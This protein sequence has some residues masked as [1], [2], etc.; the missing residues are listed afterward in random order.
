[1]EEYESKEL[2]SW[3]MKE[4]NIPQYWSKGL[5]GNGIKIAVLDSGINFNHPDIGT[6]VKDGFNALNPGTLPI[7]DYGHGTLMT[8]IIGSEH[9][10]FG[11][12]GIAP[13]SEIYPVKVLDRFGEGEFV[14]I[15]RGIDWCIDNNIDV[16]N[17]SF[18]VPEDHPELKH[19]I[20]K[21]LDKNI[22]IVAS[23]MN[24]YGEIS[25]YPASYNGVISVTSVDKYFRKGE[26]A[27]IGDIDFAMPGVDVITTSNDLSYQYVSGTSIA[28]PH[29]TGLIALMLQDSHMNYSELMEQLKAK[30]IDIGDEGFD[31]DFG[32]GFINL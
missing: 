4:M 30:A 9:N 10:S 14:H 5:T 18:A 21:A 16:I 20:N 17:M 31:S 7:D 3:G 29:L 25:G 1:M 2:L 32:W 13:D 12:K 26:S 6:N 15:Q 24:S 19:A 8:G 27:S 22:I 23:V 11:I 28:A